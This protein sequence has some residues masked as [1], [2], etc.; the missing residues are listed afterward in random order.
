MLI[1][2][3]KR[4]ILSFLVALCA[5]VL[6]FALLRLQGNA[7]TALA[8]EGARPE[9]IAIIIQTYGLDRPLAI[10]Y[11]SWLGDVLRG[12]FGN[13][14]FFRTPVADLI[15]KKFG[16]T[17]ILAIL[18]LTIS[19]AISIPMGVLAAVYSGS[20]IDRTCATISLMGQ[21]LPSFFL[22]LCLVMLFAIQ[23]RWFPAS[24]DDSLRH[25]ILPAITLGYYITPPFMR[26]VRAGMIDALSNDYVR[27]ARAKGLPAHRVILK[28]A[29]RNALVPV[30]GLVAVQLGLLIGGSVVIETI[31]AIDG[32]GY[33]A[34]QSIG[35]RDFPVL[36]AV[37]LLLSV[38]YVA[39]TLVA[40]LVNAWL[41]PRLRVS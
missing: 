25:F 3:S 27:T 41:D 19:L 26:L 38:I 9:D 20:W 8:G 32:L 33:L 28:H 30:V 22:A 11:V 18:S 13:S 34:Y 4:L 37:V 5:S 39:L 31:F 6:A 35:Y 10:Q 36:Q 21:A 2:L 24:G 14:Y 16:N 12:D 7:A 15:F 23:L 40:D 1:Y 29:L 17:I